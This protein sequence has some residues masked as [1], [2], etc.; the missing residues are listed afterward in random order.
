M[1]IWISGP[2]GEL[3]PGVGSITGFSFP[4][5]PSGS[6]PC[7]P[8]CDLRGGGTRVSMGFPAGNCIPVPRM[9]CGDGFGNAGCAAPALPLQNPFLWDSLV[10]SLWQRMENPRI[11]TWGRWRSGSPWLPSGS[12][13]W[14][15]STWRP[16]ACTVPSSPTSSRWV[17]ERGWMSPGAASPDP[18]VPRG[19]I[20]LGM[21]ALGY[22][23]GDVVIPFSTCFH[24]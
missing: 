8:G 20:L 11:R 3:D 13:D 12:R 24:F 7:F 23:E 17:L 4:W 10:F 22:W 14:F 9:V 5:D 6:L 16:G 18:A 15:R 1:G 21:S 2:L 19:R